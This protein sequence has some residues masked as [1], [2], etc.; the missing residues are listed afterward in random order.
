MDAEDGLA[1][2]VLP[3][4]GEG[5]L[6][7]LLRLL[8]LLPLLL[9][10]LPP[11]LFLLGLLLLRLVVHDTFAYPPS[12]SPRQPLEFGTVD[13]RVWGVVVGIPR[14]RRNLRLSFLGNPF[15]ISLPEE[16]FPQVGAVCKLLHIFIA[17]RD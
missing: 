13:G 16:R 9:L 4:D 7:Q 12:L 3:G 2:S 17:L 11:E 6:P 5:R 15:S 10:L 8:L 14:V 1:K